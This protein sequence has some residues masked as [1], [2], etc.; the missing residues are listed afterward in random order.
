MIFLKIEGLL[1]EFGFECNCLPLRV[2]KELH[3]RL[4]EELEEIKAK[5]Q[6]VEKIKSRLLVQIL[7]DL[8]HKKDLDENEIDALL[9]FALLV[10]YSSGDEGAY[11]HIKNKFKNH[12]I[13]ERYKILFSEYFAISQD[14]INHLL[15]EYRNEY[16]PEEK[17]KL[18]CFLYK[19]YS[20]M[21]IYN[22]ISEIVKE[23]DL[24]F[25][26]NYM[27][28]SPSFFAA[29]YLALKASNV[30]LFG[31]EGDINEIIK[32]MK[33]TMETLSNKFLLGRYHSI[34]SS[35]YV[36]L[37][38]LDK[39]QVHADLAVS[40]YQEHCPSRVYYTYVNKAKIAAF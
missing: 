22:V 33:L 20:W 12:K 18:G 16:D 11:N 3:Q 21:G 14:T 32:Q 15:V 7:L 34:I 6:S 37:K 13:V 23:L 40:M 39:A 19:Y 30:L 1:K 9:D 31:Q 35:W 26:K 38:D 10:I 28:S 8:L 27:I 2:K 5:K 4:V 17:M 24:I 29:Y 36:E 25:E